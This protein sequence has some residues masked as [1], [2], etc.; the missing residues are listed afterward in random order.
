MGFFKKVKDIIGIEE[1]ENE[2][3][4]Q[5][6]EAEKTP[7]EPERV[8]RQER[9]ERKEHAERLERTAPLSRVTTEEPAVSKYQTGA[10]NRITQQ[11]K[12]IVIEPKSINDCQK[13][14]DSLKAKKPIIIN[15]ENVESDMARKI[16]DFLSGATYALSGNIQKVSANIF[17]FAPENVDISVPEENHGNFSDVVKSP[18]R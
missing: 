16:F 15:L 9:M 1:I 18:W 2:E 10:L 7:K 11:M 13:L 4:E 8:T 6:V 3:V 14:V 12:M 5:E 17:L